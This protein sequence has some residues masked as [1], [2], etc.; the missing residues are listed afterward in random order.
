VSFCDYQ[1]KLAAQKAVAAQA[2]ADEGAL[3]NG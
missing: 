1:A 3:L 2:K